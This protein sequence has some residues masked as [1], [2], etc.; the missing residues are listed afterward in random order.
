MLGQMQGIGDKGQGVRVDLR[1]DVVPVFGQVVD[2]L[3]KR[4]ANVAVQTIKQILK[5]N[6]PIENNTKF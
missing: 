6:Y 3:V 4:V 5:L 2:A 1:V